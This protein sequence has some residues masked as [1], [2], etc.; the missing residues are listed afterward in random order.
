MNLRPWELD[1]VQKRIR[2]A[3]IAQRRYDRDWD[4]TDA[5]FMGFL[6]GLCSLIMII[7]VLAVIQVE[8][9]WKYDEPVEEQTQPAVS[10]PETGTPRRRP[11]GARSPGDPRGER[12]P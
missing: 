11:P 8:G 4:S 7:V 1:P 12:Y 3:Q 10:T 2:R 5:G 6:I 9:Y